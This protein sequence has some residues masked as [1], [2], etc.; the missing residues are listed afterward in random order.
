MRKNHPFMQVKHIIHP[1]ILWSYG[2]SFHEHPVTQKRSGNQVP[3][4]EE[5]SYNAVWIRLTVREN[6]PAKQPET[7]DDPGKHLTFPICSM[8]Y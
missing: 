8:E 7:L 2:M 6:P 3:K 4:M 5:S 1:W